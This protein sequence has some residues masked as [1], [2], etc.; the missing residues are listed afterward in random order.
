MKLLD[1]TIIAESVIA[2]VFLE[3][4]AMCPEEKGGMTS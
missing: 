4:R 2:D 3:S 1:S